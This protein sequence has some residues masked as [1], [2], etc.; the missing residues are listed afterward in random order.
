MRIFIVLWF[1]KSSS[2]IYELSIAIWASTSSIYW[3]KCFYK[4][5][6]KWIWR[7]CIWSESCFTLFPLALLIGFFLTCSLLE[8]CELRI[9]LVFRWFDSQLSILTF[10]ISFQTCRNFKPWWSFR[11]RTFCYFTSFHSLSSGFKDR[12][13]AFNYFWYLFLR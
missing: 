8:L 13:R 11:T 9:G 7:N 12:V 2:I 10:K 5:G 1:Q 6:P 3:K 4:L